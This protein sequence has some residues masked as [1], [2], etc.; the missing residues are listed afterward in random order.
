MNRLINRLI[1]TTALNR[2]LI[3]C[4]IAP[5]V[6]FAATLRLTSDQAS[7]QLAARL[8]IAIAHHA[9]AQNMNEAVRADLFAGV[10][11]WTTR[12]SEGLATAKRAAQT[13][14]DRAQAALSRINDVLASTPL[15]RSAIPSQGLLARST[16]L[17]KDVLGPNVHSLERIEI[18]RYSKAWNRNQ[19]AL[20][21]LGTVL[22]EQLQ[23]TQVTTAALTQWSPA[24]ATTLLILI[25]F[26]GWACVRN[27]SHQHTQ[28]HRLV[29]AKLAQAVE[30]LRSMPDDADRPIAYCLDTTRQALGDFHRCANSTA[31]AARTMQELGHHAK[32]VAKDGSERLD[33]LASTI[34]QMDENTQ[35]VN[36]SLSEI[37]QVAFRTNVLALN[38]QV[39]ATRAGEN[40]RSFAL[41]AN[42][43]RT[44]ALRTTETASNMRARL[45]ETSARASSGSQVASGI[46][47][48][49]RELTDTVAVLGSQLND[50]RDTSDNQEDKVKGVAHAVNGLNDV[51]REQAIWRTR[52]EEILSLLTTTRTQIHAASVLVQ[53]TDEGDAVDLATDS[54]SPGSQGTRQTARQ[55]KSHLFENTIERPDTLDTQPLQSVDKF[56]N[57]QFRR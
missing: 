22:Q 1:S 20:T 13:H 42:E 26:L 21:S 10:L 27:L 2:W 19:Q 24:T 11:A 51:V 38:A 56:G 57:Q 28:T 5:V 17:I 15:D 30:Q 49:M 46:A 33:E 23:S 45:A 55:R 37:E 43:V 32:H 18:Q 40:G 9:V 16:I 47:Q 6:L 50:L 39:E 35:R 34:T 3:V 44:L 41:L 54:G 48:T 12:D 52:R 25:G 4:L 31:V 8:Q 36:R 14:S 7:S 29:E 53:S